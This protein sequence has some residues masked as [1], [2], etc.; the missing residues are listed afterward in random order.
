MIPGQ[1]VLWPVF[2]TRDPP[3]HKT[4]YR[5]N[6]NLSVSL[7]SFVHGFEPFVIPDFD[8]GC[9]HSDQISISRNVLLN[10][11]IREMFTAFEISDRCNQLFGNSFL[12][13]RGVLGNY[14]QHTALWST[15]L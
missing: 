3:E 13:G 11:V 12:T 6:Q 10:S 9:L 1:I 8:L 15:K 4:G 2:E 5:F 7:R 14:L